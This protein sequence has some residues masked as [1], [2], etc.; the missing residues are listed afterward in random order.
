MAATGFHDLSGLLRVDQP[1]RRLHGWQVR[2]EDGDKLL[3]RLFTDAECGGRPQAHL[4]AVAHRDAVRAALLGQSPV[5][6]GSRYISRLDYSRVRGWWVRVPD[7]SSRLVSRLFSDTLHGGTEAAH[8]AAI[9]WRDAVAMHYGKDPNAPRIGRR[10]GTK[11]KPK[12]PVILAD[13]PVAVVH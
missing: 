10:P 7:E 8:A 1:N 9:V 5:T 2:I 12:N 13:E 3:T 6:Y 11:N 4:R